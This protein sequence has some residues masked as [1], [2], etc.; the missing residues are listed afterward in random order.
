MIPRIPAQATEPDDGTRRYRGDLL[1]YLAFDGDLKESGDHGMK[2]LS[3][4]DAENNPDIIANTDIIRS[5]YTT[6][7]SIEFPV[8]VSHVYLLAP[9]VV[10]PDD[11]PL[12]MVDAKVSLTVDGMTYFSDFSAG[13]IKGATPTGQY[14][15][16]YL[17]SGG[18]TG[19]GET[20]IDPA[21]L[22][23]AS[24]IEYTVT[25]S[26][27]YEPV[28]EE[29]PAAESPEN[30]GEETAVSPEGNVTEEGMQTAADPSAP[31]PADIV[32]DGNKG[33]VDAGGLAAGIVVAVI[34]VLMIAG[35]ILLSRRKESAE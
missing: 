34:A 30:P 17:L 23:G 13:E 5:G 10:T 28:P 18:I 6:T 2:F 12:S 19:G 15:N 8:A 33:K 9:V 20:F 29:T 32:I 22:T 1:V 31:T 27:V 4:D 7:V 3:P 14:E 16:S 11:S 35:G 26:S 24:K 21:V 25:L